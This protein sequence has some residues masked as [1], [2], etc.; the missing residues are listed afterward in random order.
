MRAGLL[1]VLFCLALIS[2]APPVMARAQ[3]SAVH[4]KTKHHSADL[5]WNPP[6]DS[7]LKIAG[8]NVYRSTDG[9][10]TFE[11]LNTAPIAQP[12]YVDK[13]VQSGVTYFYQ[14]KTVDAKGAESGPSNWITLKV[15]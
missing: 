6:A 10:K 5:R 13:T 15:P 12:K 7:S 4:H 9:G 2:A 14:V 1:R 8:Y 3:K 11:K